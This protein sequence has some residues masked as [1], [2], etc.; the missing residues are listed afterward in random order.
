MLVQRH[1]QHGRLSKVAAPH[2]GTATPAEHP[3]WQHALL[4]TRQAWL[5]V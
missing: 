3:M 4:E 1:V 2:N 5:D